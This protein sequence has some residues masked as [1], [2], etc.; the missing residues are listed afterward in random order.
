M[1]TMRME[2]NYTFGFVEA[3]IFWSI[4]CELLCRLVHSFSVNSVHVDLGTCQ[5]RVW[6]IIAACINSRSL[7]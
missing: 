5:Y 1:T 3:S 6:C 2:F 7:Q 4:R